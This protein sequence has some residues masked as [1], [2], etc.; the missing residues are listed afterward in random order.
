MKIDKSEYE[1]IYNRKKNGESVIKLA[2]EYG[3]KKSAIYRIIDILNTNKDIKLNKLKKDL[4]REINI[5]KLK[6]LAK[7]YDIKITIND[8]KYDCDACEK[9]KDL[10][11]EKEKRIK[12]LELDLQNVIKYYETVLKYRYDQMIHLNNTLVY[13]MDTSDN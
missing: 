5:K 3:V 6:D 4:N 2:K 12:E 11:L 8:E 9:F 10:V 1:V 7:K 13:Q